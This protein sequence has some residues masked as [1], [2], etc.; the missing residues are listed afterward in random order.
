MSLRLR[1]SDFAKFELLDI[2]EYIAKHNLTA[3]NRMTERITQ[4][5]DLLARHPNIGPA[6]DE[7]AVGLRSFPVG[8][9]VILY[10]VTDERLLIERVVHGARDFG[11]LF[12]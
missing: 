12:K 8:S 7:I 1:V 11:A 10:R 2:W 5:Y 9:Y 3:A 4:T 6:R